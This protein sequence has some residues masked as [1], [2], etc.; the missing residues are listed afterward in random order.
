M[1]GHFPRIDPSLP[2][3]LPINQS[4][5]SSVDRNQQAAEEGIQ[6]EG[7]AQRLFQP[8][9]PRRSLEDLV[10]SQSLRESIGAALNQISFADELYSPT[11]WNL[12]SVDPYG[13]RTSLNLYGPPGTGKSF[14]AE[15]IASN[16]GKSIIKV[17]YADIQSKYP[18]DTEKAIASVFTTAKETDSVIFFDEADA[19]LSKRLFQQ[20]AAVDVSVNSIRAVMLLQLDVFSGIVIFATNSFE[21][22]DKAFIRRILAHI[23]FELPSQEERLDLWNNLLPNQVPRSDDVDLEWLSSISEGLAGGDILNIVKLAAGRAI[24][25][26]G[27]TWKL[28]RK[29]LLSASDEVRR[30]KEQNQLMSETEREISTDEL[31]PSAREAYDKVISEKEITS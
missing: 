13:P 4:Q 3:E 14:C 17:N 16:L 7:K 15:A 31:P 29:D 6:E 19:I 11:G 9:K 30:A 10:I 12:Q 26:R 5:K 22:F 28:L 23:Q 25:R 27:D 8:Q 20:D 21:N 2:L 18:G 1:P 24:Q